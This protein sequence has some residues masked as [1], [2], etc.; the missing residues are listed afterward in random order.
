MAEEFLNGPN[1][2]PTF[3]HVS[4]KAMTEHVGRDPFFDTRFF[5]RIAHCILI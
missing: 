3:Q 2:C 5:R 1:I 4:G